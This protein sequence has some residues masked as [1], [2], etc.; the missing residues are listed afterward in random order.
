MNASNALH[1][2]DDQLARAVVDEAELPSP[3]REHLSTCPVCRANRE[4][5]ARNLARLGRMA[6]RFAPSPTKRIALPADE[7]G[8]MV[9]WS[10]GWRT[11]VGAAVAAVLALAVLWRVPAF[12]NPSEEKGNTVAVEMQQAEDFMTE[13]AM[14]VDNPLPAVYQDVSAESTI[15][16][17]E[18][19][20][21][22]VV[23]SVENEPLTQNDR[24]R[25]VSLC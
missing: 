19:L 17:D 8:S 25:G 11:Y 9:R 10:W 4:Q 21:E 16:E 20:T 14:L 3:L 12:R 1:L 23:P 13:I 5:T 24:K 15:D 18:D 6:A 7:P 2:D 22:F